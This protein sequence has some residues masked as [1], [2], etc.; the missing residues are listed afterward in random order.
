MTNG[1]FHDHKKLVHLLRF[2]SQ[3]IFQTYYL[4]IDFQESNRTCTLSGTFANLMLANVENRRTLNKEMRYQIQNNTSRHSASRLLFLVGMPATA[5]M[6]IAMERMSRH[7]SMPSK[8]SAATSS[9]NVS[10]SVN[11]HEANNYL[12]FIFPTHS[13]SLPSSLCHMIMY[14]AR[15]LVNTLMLSAAWYL[16]HDICIKFYNKTRPIIQ[17]CVSLLKQFS[18]SMH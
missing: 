18:S 14:A 3:E 7:R 15:S 11:E 1:L 10:K 5:E 9:S 8:S 12:Y 2:F 13:I 17:N 16:R 6:P 4:S